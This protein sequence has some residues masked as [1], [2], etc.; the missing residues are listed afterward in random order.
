VPIVLTVPRSVALRIVQ[1]FPGLDLRSTI[2]AWG[3]IRD[4]HHRWLNQPPAVTFRRR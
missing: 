1:L 4:R 2:Q 3:E